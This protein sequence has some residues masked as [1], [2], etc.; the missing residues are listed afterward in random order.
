VPK[1]LQN[2]SGA[3]A[4]ASYPSSAAIAEGDTT[5]NP[6]ITGEIRWSTTT[7]T[8][9]QWDGSQWVSTGL[10]GQNLQRILLGS[11]VSN[12]TTSLADAT[13]LSFSVKNGVSY[14][15]RFWVVFQ[16]AATTTGCSLS[17][18]AP[19][20]SLLAYRVEIPT[21]ASASVLGFKRAVNTATTG[22]D[23]DSATSNL[24]AFIEGVLVPSADGTLIVRFASEVAAS[25]CTIKAGSNGDLIALS[26][27]SPSPFENTTIGIDTVSGTTYTAVQGDQ[28]RI[29][30]C[31]NSSAVALTI[32]PNSSVP[33][34]IGA[35]I[36]VVQD[37]TGQVTLVAGAGV[38]LSNALTLKTRAQYSMLTATK[39]A[40]DTWWVT[41]D[42]ATS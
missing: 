2:S 25:N 29:K 15:F 28:G 34:S 11:D 10:R 16:T 9:M 31:T 3:I 27:S 22:T 33:Y 42:M 26:N 40:T 38:T 5:P 13:G 23:V 30:A 39:K 6:G 1:L 4:E 21:S 24:L 36:S 12:S 14:R 17:V 19:S 37:G 8:L 20:T 18:N 32:P 7:S 35:S 41:G